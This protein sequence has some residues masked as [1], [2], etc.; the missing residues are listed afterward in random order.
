MSML[1]R[2]K[3]HHIPSFLKRA[4]VGFSSFVN[5]S[6][7]RMGGSR[8]PIF[9]GATRSGEISCVDRT[10]V[11]KGRRPLNPVLPFNRSLLVAPLPLVS[12]PF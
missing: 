11:P 9:A 10:L 3:M 12:P 1:F 5:M 6:G 4:I 2:Y 8:I 7:A